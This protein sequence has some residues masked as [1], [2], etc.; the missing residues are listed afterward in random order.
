MSIKQYGK[1]EQEKTIE[2]MV[3]CREIVQEI[4]DFGV[5]QPQIMKIAYLLSLEL[6]NQGAVEDIS[7]CIQE[8]IDRLTNQDSEIVIT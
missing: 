8:H 1:T 4:L 3:Q 5:T 7:R 2:D 6:E